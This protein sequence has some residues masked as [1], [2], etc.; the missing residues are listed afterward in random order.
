[1]DIEVQ[2]QGDKLRVLT[3]TPRTPEAVQTCS[4]PRPRAETSGAGMAGSCPDTSPAGSA[5]PWDVLHPIQ[6]LNH[7]S[8]FGL[9]STQAHHN[10]ISYSMLVLI[11]TFSMHGG[12]SPFT[13][14]CPRANQSQEAEAVWSCLI[15]SWATTQG[16][17]ARLLLEFPLQL[18]Q[19]TGNSSPIQDNTCRQRAI[20]STQQCLWTVI[21]NVHLT[22]YLSCQYL[23]GLQLLH[24]VQP[25]PC[26]GNVLFP[27]LGQ[28]RADVPISQAQHL[29]CSHTT[30]ATSPAPP[31]PMGHQ[32]DALQLHQQ[33]L[34]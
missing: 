5:C 6:V 17:R 33:H 9:I 1:M 25:F 30:C 28:G 3:S 34:L 32:L 10:S 4:V 2:L 13:S 14:F 15:L 19:N 31:A 18:Q 11:L 7:V 24:Y 21:T 29:P 12:K 20:S 22:T 16:Q 27:E 26:M 8:Q 23:P